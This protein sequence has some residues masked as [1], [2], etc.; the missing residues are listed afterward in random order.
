MMTSPGQ[1]PTTGAGAYQSRRIVFFRRGGQ[2]TCPDGHRIPDGHFLVGD[3]VVYRC[4]YRFPGGRGHSNLGE[5]GK[6]IFVFGLGGP[7]QV[8]GKD[9]QP[10]RILA[11]AEITPRERGELTAGHMQ[12]PEEILSFLGILL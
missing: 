1:R 7:S 5:C 6:L 3:V 8:R 2:I 11:G 4:S 12:T 9:G 10:V